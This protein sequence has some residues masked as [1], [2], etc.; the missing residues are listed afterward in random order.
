MKVIKNYI[1]K[2]VILRGLIRSHRKIRCHPSTP[3]RVT[4][5]K[6]QNDPYPGDVSNSPPPKRLVYESRNGTRSAARCEI[7][8][9]TSVVA[10]YRTES[11]IHRII[12]A[13][14]SIIVYILGMII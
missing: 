1:Y 9:Q 7:F 5:L 4:S 8:V 2:S 6:F 13:I 11:S 10:G 12:A 14:W 3:L